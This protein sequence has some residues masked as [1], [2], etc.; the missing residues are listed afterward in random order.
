M[1]R[2]KNTLNAADVSSTPIKVKYFA[3][4]PTSSFS[5]NGIFLL[6]GSNIPYS[7]D[8][9]SSQVSEMNNYRL[10]KQLYYENYLTG[11][12]LPSASFFYPWWQSTAASASGDAT[13]YQL[14]TSKNDPVL[15]ISISPRTF[16]EQVSRGTFILSAS[17]STYYI[18]DDGNG[19]LYDFLSNNEHVGN[20]FYSQGIAVITNQDY[21]PNP[22]N[23]YLITEAEDIYNTE[24]E[25]NIIIE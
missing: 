7:A 17:D 3:S 12:I 9:S 19:N 20:I 14:P 21:A 4:Y 10:V 2:A 15:I 16:G 1:G 24:A 11:S 5:E 25:I 18:V 6:T 22:D 8:L 13:I 23:I